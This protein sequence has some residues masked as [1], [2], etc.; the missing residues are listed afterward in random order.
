MV[1]V[2]GNIDRISFDNSTACDV[3][4]EVIGVERDARLVLGTAR[5]ATITTMEEIL[6]QG[7]VWIFLFGSQGTGGG[8][9]RLTR[10]QLERDRLKVAMRA[11]IGAGLE[12]EGVPPS[13]RTD[14]DLEKEIACNG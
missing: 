5:R 8:E 2:Q 6:D 14:R 9:L 1:A 3:D 13:P 7:D 12:A 10:E 4:V 11:R